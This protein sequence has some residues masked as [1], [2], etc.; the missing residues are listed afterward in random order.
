MFRFIRVYLVIMMI[1]YIPIAFIS[2][3]W[4]PSD[5]HILGRVLLAGWGLLA[6]VGAAQASEE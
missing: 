1:F 6:L 4:N 2:Q 5:W 3:V